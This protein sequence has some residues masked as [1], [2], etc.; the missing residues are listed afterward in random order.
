M[1]KVGSQSVYR[2]LLK[3]SEEKHMDLQ[4]YK[5]HVL[6]DLERLDEIMGQVR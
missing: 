1:G 4:T 6:H 5:I 3:F 2:S